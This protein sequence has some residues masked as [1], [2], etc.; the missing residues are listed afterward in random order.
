MSNNKGKLKRRRIR[1]NQ[2]NLTT[3]EKIVKHIMQNEGVNAQEAW[4]RFRMRMELKAIDNGT[5][6]S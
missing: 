2:N 1:A 5:F 3:D 6:N 4:R